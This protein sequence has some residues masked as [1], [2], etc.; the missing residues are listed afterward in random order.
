MESFAANLWRAGRK[1]AA[2]A[3]L[4]LAIAFL[5]LPA[6]ALAPTERHFRVEARSFAY[7]PAVISVNPGDRVT[8]DLAAVDVVHGL[9]IDGYNLSVSADPGQT[10]HL[11]FVADRLGTFRLRCSVACGA[12]HPFMLGK[13]TVGQNW[14]GWRA[15]GLLLLAAVAGVGMRRS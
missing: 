11:T 10:A 5:P 2:L 15:A 4:G 12:L 8:I 3:L 6:S 1:W 14:L 7:T 13:L 9:S